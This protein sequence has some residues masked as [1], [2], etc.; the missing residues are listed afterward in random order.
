VNDVLNSLARAPKRED[1]VRVLRPL[2]D[3]MDPLQV[4][5]LCA[6]ILRDMK[7][8]VTEKTVLKE[9]H[10]DAEL[11]FNNCCD[12]RKARPTPAPAPPSRQPRPDLRRRRALLPQQGPRAALRLRAGQAHPAAAGA[13]VQVDGCADGA[14]RASKGRVR[15]VP[16]PPTPPPHAPVS[17]IAEVKFD[18]ERIQ[19]HR[20]GEAMNYWTRNMHDYGPRGYNVFDPVVKAQLQRQR[21]MLDG[22]LVIYHK[23]L[24]T[25]MAFGSLKTVMW[26]VRDALKCAAEALPFT[27]SAAF[28]ERA[29]RG[30]AGRGE[31]DEEEEEEEREGGGGVAARQYGSGATAKSTQVHEGP[32]LTRDDLSEVEVWF[33][34]FDILYDGD[35]SVIDRPLRERHELLRAAVRE[36]DEDHPVML[37]PPGCP[38]PVCGRIKLL[39]PGS[40]WSFPVASRA[41]I[42]RCMADGCA[43]DEEGLVLKNLGSPWA[44]GDRSSSWIK[45]KPDYLPTEDLDLLV[46]G[47]YMGTGARRG[48]KL[49]SFLMGLAE[50]PRGGGEPHTFHSFTKVGSGLTEEQLEALRAKLLPLMGPWAADA[51]GRRVPAATKDNAPA[52]YRCTGHRNETPELWVL[53]PRQSVVLTIK[54]DVRLIEDRI[55]YSRHALRFPRVTAM[56]EQKRWADVFSD[57]DLAR[58][59]ADT[60]GRLRMQGAA[61]G[62]AAAAGARGAKRAPAR[63]PAKPRARVIAPGGVTGHAPARAPPQ[64]GHV[65]VQT[66]LLTDPV[67]LTPM[68]INVLHAPAAEKAAAQ[69]MVVRHGGVVAASASAKTHYVLSSWFDPS[70][71]SCMHVEQLDKPVLTFGWLRDCVEASALLPPRPKHQL[72]FASSQRDEYGQDRFGDSYSEEVDAEDVEALLRAAKAAAEDEAVRAAALAAAAARARPLSAQLLVAAAAA[73]PPPPSAQQMLAEERSLEGARYGRL[74]GARLLL[75][76][77]PP[78]AASRGF[79]TAAARA[80]EAADEAARQPALRRLRLAVRLHGGELVEEPRRATHIV[81]MPHAGWAGGAAA[82]AALEEVEAALGPMGGDGPPVVRLDW[83]HARLAAAAAAEETAAP[84]A[85]GFLLLRKRAREEESQQ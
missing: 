39:L 30:G 52:C 83:L 28:A 26:H 2:L 67:D 75:L 62:S 6:I 40:P 9:F 59:V 19:L 20:D 18:G 46:I 10:V 12:L 17:Y 34:A 57:V 61:A 69:E 44:L 16:R 27:A 70:K 43:R 3:R 4:K 63:A 14:D 56:D 35:R 78:P 38:D 51:T 45:L 76:P 49:S 29:G 55:F 8:G 41:D 21:C 31:A 25:F 24:R 79:A 77:L 54:S 74:R 23:T 48:G 73:A 47:G 68:Q 15:L 7:I 84:S 60:N 37:T 33:I 42:E 81:A 72:R 32:R 85:L 80:A 36:L 58:L 64:L 65:E 1:K 71:A 82:P 13:D 11:A 66:R 50:A 53:D 22:E 5:W